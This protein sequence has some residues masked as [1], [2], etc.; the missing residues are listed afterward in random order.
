MQNIKLLIGMLLGTVIVVTIIA[1]AFSQKTS[2]PI[3]MKRLVG[4]E[5]HATGSA[6]P[7]VTL[8]EFSDFQCPACRAVQP[9]VE[10]LI[11][12]YGEQLRFIY[13]NFPLI[14][15]HKNSQAAALAAETAGSVNKYWEYHNILFERQQE[16]SEKSAEEAESIF[17]AYGTLLGIPPE[18]M[19][20]SL[21]SKTFEQQI[22][23]DVKDGTALGVSATPTF[24]VNSQKTSVQDLEQ[25]IANL[26][27]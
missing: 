5:R 7:K 9:L 27:K 19:K 20:T 2:A 18:L 11:T 13:R 6:T 16:W 8:V 3:E 4:D 17:I 15:I 12:Q 22:Q 14:A 21:S 24:Y 25:T 10:Q 26:L 1:I 23:N